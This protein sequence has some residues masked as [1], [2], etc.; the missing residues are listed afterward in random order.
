MLTEK[1]LKELIKQG[2]I[3][4]NDVDFEEEQQDDLKKQKLQLEQ[5]KI[6]LQKQKLEVEKLKLQKKQQ[7]EQEEHKQK[8]FD[9]MTIFYCV[10][11]LVA[12]LVYVFVYFCIIKH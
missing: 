3:Q 12:V 2:K 8:R 4:T 9:G 5:Q 11:G 1:D 7:E 10:C 6:E